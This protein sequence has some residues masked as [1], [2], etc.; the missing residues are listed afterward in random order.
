MK[1]SGIDVNDVI[2]LIVA[3]LTISN[4]VLSSKNHAKLKGIDQAVNQAEPG[5]PT[6]RETVEEVKE[7]V[8]TPD[9]ATPSIGEAVEGIARS[10]ESSTARETTPKGQ[11]R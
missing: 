1:A 9:P 8:T 7:K 11:T 3:F 10:L 2:L 4:T 5:A 6:L